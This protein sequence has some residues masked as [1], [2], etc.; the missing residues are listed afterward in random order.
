MLRYI[1][2]LIDLL[3]DCYNYNFMYVSIDA[4]NWF[5]CTDVVIVLALKHKYEE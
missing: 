4:N 5:Y 1:E 2:F 3:Y